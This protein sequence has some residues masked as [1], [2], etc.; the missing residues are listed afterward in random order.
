[1]KD[2]EALTTMAL[3]MFYGTHR[4]VGAWV[5][6]VNGLPTFLP[7]DEFCLLLLMKIGRN[8]FKKGLQSRL[9][10]EEHIVY[11]SLI[12][13]TCTRMCSSVILCTVVSQSE[14]VYS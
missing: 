3:S 5:G 8:V 11:S 9:S 14:L 1:M 7:I 12:V 2:S 13:H 4:Y 6:V 10:H